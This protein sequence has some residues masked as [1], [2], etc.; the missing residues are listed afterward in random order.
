M[1]LESLLSDSAF[2]YL[3]QDPPYLVGTGRAVQ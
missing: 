1:L 3:Y 2:S